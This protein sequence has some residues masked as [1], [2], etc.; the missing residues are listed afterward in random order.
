MVSMYLVPSQLRELEILE[1]PVKDF[2]E[3]SSLSIEVLNFLQSKHVLGGLLRN[4]KEDPY[5]FSLSEHY[6]IL[7]KIVIY[8]NQKTGFR[9]RVHL[10]AN[11]YFDRPHNHRWSYSSHILSGGYKHT[12]YHLKPSEQAPIPSDLFPTLIRREQ[13][14]DLYTLHCSQYH[15]VVAETDTVSLVLRGPSEQ[16]RFRVMDNVTNEA[17]WQYGAEKENHVERQNKQISHEQLHGAIEKL[18][19]LGLIV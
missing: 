17:W 11:G 6:D 19:Q 9:I 2:E 18:S 1:Q 16:D 7:D 15:S 14:G 12:I 8:S 5:L 10:F 3:F 4:V 13:T